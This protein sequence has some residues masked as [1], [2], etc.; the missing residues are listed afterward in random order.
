MV[1]PPP[2]SRDHRLGSQ[3]TGGVRVGVSPGFVERASWLLRDSHS[4]L[5]QS[6]SRMREADARSG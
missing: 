6:R 2:R 5:P 3:P 4:K 1:R